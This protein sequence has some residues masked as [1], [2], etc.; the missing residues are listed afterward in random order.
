MSLSHQ[1]S[2]CSRLAN[3]WDSRYCRHSLS[4]SARKLGIRFEPFRKR[5]K[6]IRSASA[7]RAVSRLVSKS[8]FSSQYVHRRR[9]SVGLTVGRANA[10]S[11]PLITDPY[12]ANAL[13]LPKHWCPRAQLVRAFSVNPFATARSN[14]GSR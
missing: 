13:R 12:L 6:A 4:H 5:R 8:V 14:R 7:N 2:F 9:A 3:G 11:S 1:L 10:G